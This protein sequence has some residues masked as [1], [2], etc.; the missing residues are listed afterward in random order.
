[1]T[2]LKFIFR[3][4]WFFRK[5]QIT[6]LAGTILSTAVLTGALIIGD[7]VKHSLREMVD[8]RLGE[9][10][11]AL[12]TGDRFVSTQLAY[13]LSSKL[14]VKAASILM[15][16]GI[17]INSES[18]SRINSIQVLGIDSNFWQFSKNKISELTEDEVVIS[19][20]TADKL[21][22]KVGQE[23]LLR[24]ENVSIIPLNAPFASQEQPS[25]SLRLKIK[26]IAAEGD[27]GRFSLRSNQAAPYNVFLSQTLLADKLKLQGLVNTIILSDNRQNINIEQINQAF[28]DSW[29]L[30]DASLEIKKLDGSGKLELLSNRIFI[31]DK[32]TKTIDNLKFTKESILTYLVNAIR[33]GGKSTPYSF[34]SALDMEIIPSKLD[35]DE[36]VINSWLAD[37]LQAKTGD[38]IHLDYYIIGSLRNLKEVSTKF[39]IKAIIPT[40][41]NE[42]YKSLMPS[43]PGL[44]EAGH[45]RDWQAGVPIDLSK[46]RDK[47]EAYWNV[48]R[49][50][51]KGYISINTGHKIWKNQFGSLSAIRFDSSA[52]NPLRLEK[53]LLANLSPLDFNLNFQPVYEQGIAATTNA[54]DFGELFLSLSFFV[55]IAAVMLTMLIH[56]LNI[57]SRSV[58]TGLLEGIGFSKKAVLKIRII[59]SLIIILIGG[60]LGA[61]AGILYNYALLAGLNSV[62]N[63]V[64]GT[65]MIGVY[66]NPTTLL[67]GSI[68]GIVV[69]LIPVIFVTRKKMRQTVT[70]LIKNNILEPKNI[71]A[72]KPF[73]AKW[74][75]IISLASILAILIYSF[76]NSVDNNS[77][78][79][80][81]SGALFLAAGISFMS[82]YL[83]KQHSSKYSLAGIGSLA[84]RNTIRNKSRSLATIGLL[85]LGVFVILITGAN[86]RTFY[87]E[88]DI[89]QS[90]TGG[91]L[92]WAETSL[93]IQYN[94]N[95][96]EGKTKLGIEDNALPKDIK[97]SQ[98]H[99]LS[100]DDASCL[101]LNQVQKPQILGVNANEFNERKSFSFASVLEGIDVENPWLSLNQLKNNNLIPAVADLTVLTWGLK[102]AIGDTLIYLNEEGKEIKLLIIGGLNNSIFQ[103][104]LLIADSLFVKNFPSVSGS[105]VMLIDAPNDKKQT[106]E[107][108]LNTNLTDYGIEISQSTTRLAE[109]NSVTNTYLSVFMALGGLGVLIGTIGLG[110]VLL[111]NMFERKSEF[112]LLQAIGFNNKQIFNLVLKENLFLLI[113]GIAIG[114]LAAIIGILPS[115]LSPSF[116]LPGMFVVFLM[117]IVLLSG[118]A[119]IYFPARNILKWNIIRTLQAE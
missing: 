73:K 59:E 90:G 103:G 105:K 102:K 40:Q 30:K 9:T 50:T 119:W 112:A 31:E 115:M 58:E 7:S 1:M 65:N 29:K 17:G 28:K 53:E 25:V 98:F 45:C 69:S 8:F 99:S 106:I 82:V 16:P 66:I 5:Q 95:N 52:I 43:F 78:L 88:E 107:N 36:I 101:N 10:R 100:G 27:I 87:G 67:I 80:L 37:D 61:L 63:E 110:I 116:E 77:S 111:R 64:V 18:N 2:I 54:V 108:Y 44:S 89:N 12:V 38:S 62:W 34:V 24:I 14:N 39:K 75:L 13:T 23:I 84:I 26:S 46:I 68:S 33:L 94:L 60:F 92:F 97:F 51:P 72:K 4:L 70:N 81:I 114:S 6:L 47:D 15:V 42:L 41:D 35:D 22:L 86:R 11:F 48:Y 117:L 96:K 3:N 85:A 83:N 71:L 109:F 76:G 93:P 49:G 55:I 104:N 79:F 74:F 118:L 113:S 20:N 21:N 32:V 19:Q 91:Y 57:E 56:G